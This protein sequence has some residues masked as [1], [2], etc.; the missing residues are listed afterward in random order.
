L[1]SL[2]AEY[3][4]LSRTVGEQQSEKRRLLDTY[5]SKVARLEEQVGTLT[6]AL[7]N[8]RTRY[9]EERARASAVERELR[10]ELAALE[11]TLRSAQSHAAQSAVAAAT[12][13]SFATAARVRSSAAMY[14][15]LPSNHDGGG[16]PQR[17]MSPSSSLSSSINSTSSN[18]NSNN[19]N[20][21]NTST[22]I[23]HHHHHSTSS[24]GGE[25]VGGVHS[26]TVT[27]D[28]F[29]NPRHLPS[30][31]T[32]S[33]SHAVD[34]NDDDPLLLLSSDAADRRQLPLSSAGAQPSR[35]TN[36]YIRP[37]SRYRPPSASD[38][39]WASGPID[40][41]EINIF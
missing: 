13:H 29:N 1:S 12:A 41:R 14:T 31:L 2:Q 40:P 37:Q 22:H 17:A 5:P 34:G 19:T 27:S 36:N 39:A 4:R 33:S 26:P 30:S 8:A 20:T 23:E 21:N 6:S 7:E 9:D 38:S 15:P 25:P 28:S 10:S 11:G 32:S 18:A 24:M 3:A 16:S 35:R